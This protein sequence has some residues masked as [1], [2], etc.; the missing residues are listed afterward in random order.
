MNRP[1]DDTYSSGKLRHEV[2]IY[3]PFT[4]LVTDNLSQS[5]I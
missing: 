5:T 1:K 3:K 2:I 4:Y